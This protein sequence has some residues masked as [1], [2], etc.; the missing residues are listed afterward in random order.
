M[1]SL[2]ALFPGADTRAI[3]DRLNALIREYNAAR[4][5]VAV[6]DLPDADKNTGSRRLVND[7][8]A[9][10]FWSVVANGGANVVPVTS[11]GTDWRIG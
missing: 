3:T 7:A 5:P 11:D 4:N 1:S 9:T 6:D 2:P 10:T 8:N